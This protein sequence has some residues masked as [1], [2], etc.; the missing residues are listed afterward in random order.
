LLAPA[1]LTG[2]EAAETPEPLLPPRVS[3]PAQADIDVALAL[4]AEPTAPAAPAG[5]QSKAYC[6]DDMVDVA[7]DYCENVAQYCVRYDGNPGRDR[8]LEFRAGS[9]CLGPTKPVR[10]CVDRYEYPNRAGDKPIVAVDWEQAGEL[11]AAEGKRLCSASEWTLACEGPERLPYPY[12]YSRDA[13]ACNIDKPYITPDNS[14]F[15]N[16]ATRDAEVA[17]VDQ[18][19]PSGA[20]ESCV[21]PYGVHDMTGNVDEWVNNE[22]G[23]ENSRPYNS[24]LK[25]GWWG[26][27]RNR[28]RPMTVDHNQWHLGYQ[29]GFRCCSDVR[30]SAPAPAASGGSGEPTL[31]GS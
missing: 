8:C 26:P 18:R 25:G 6:P 9:Q 27:V 2:A 14:A 30:Q 29:I 13:Q 24:G 11:C 23:S 19:E 22:A 12:G 3:Q 5:S 17:R 4:P 1:L 7:G 28:C 10:V 20:R 15:G 21:S 16:P 31:R